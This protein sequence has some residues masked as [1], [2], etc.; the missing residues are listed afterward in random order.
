VAHTGHIQIM[1][2]HIKNFMMLSS[3]IEKEDHWME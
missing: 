2:Q 3:G 1:K